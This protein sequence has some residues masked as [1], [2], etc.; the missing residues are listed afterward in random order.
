MNI[1]LTKYHQRFQKVLDYIDR[2][3]N[4]D[5]SLDVLSQLA[6]FSKF[7][8][9]R[10]FSELFGIGVYKYI[11]LCRLKRASYQLAFRDGQQVIEIALANAYGG[12]ASFSRAFKKSFGQSPMAFRHNPQWTPWFESYQTIFHLRRN[13][14]PYENQT[15]QVRIVDFSEI[16]LAVLEYK[17]DPKFVGNSIR[18]FIQ[19]RKEHHL[20]PQNSATFNILYNDPEAVAAE[21]YRIDICVATDKAIAANDQGVI[22]KT[23]PAGRCAVLRHF[24]SDDKL[25]TSIQILYA[26]WLPQS[27][28]ELREFPMFLQRVKFFP[29]VAENEAVTD[30]YLPL[31]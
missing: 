14:M 9:Q 25:K 10:Q 16:K 20:N 13:Q 31:K 30:V 27:G 3:L 29:D 26:D 24:G 6:A 23:I 1:E 17:G 15:G 11:Q 28:E 12:P 18:K 21:D 4:D 19:W 8:F 2:H 22:P 5:L 7:H